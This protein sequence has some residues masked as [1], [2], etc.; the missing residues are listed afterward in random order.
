MDLAE[1]AS[2]DEEGGWRIPEW[3]C[4]SEHWSTDI[5]AEAQA[6]LEGNSNPTQTKN[7][8]CKTEGSTRNN[9]GKG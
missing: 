8:I 5:E 1:A 2:V 4:S 9:K 3:E 6:N 7:T